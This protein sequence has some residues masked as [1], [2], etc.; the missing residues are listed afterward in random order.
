MYCINFQ[1]A[2]RPE[3]LFQRLMAFFEDNLLAVNGGLTHHGEQVTADED[4]SPSLE[5]TIVVLWLQLIHPGLPLLVKQKYGSELHNKILASLKPEISQALSS[6][7]DE[8]RSIEDTK[9]MRISNVNPRRT[10]NGGQGQPRRR[11]FVSCI[12]CKTA[13][14]PHNTHDLMECRYLPDRDRRPWARS[15]LTN[16]DPDEFATGDC[17]PY[18]ECCDHVLPPEHSDAFTAP[19]ALSVS[20]IQSPVLNTFYHEHPVQL[21]LDT[22]ATSNMVRASAAKLYGLPVTP[23]SQMARQADG[24]TPMDVVGEVHCTLTRGQRAFELD[25]PVVR[26]LDVDILAGN[27]FLARNDI[28]I[29]PAR[30]QIVI[31][32][33]DMIHYGTASKHTTQSAVRRTQSFLLRN[34]QRT[35][36]LPGEYVQLDTPRDSD[37][38]TLWALEPRLDCPSNILLKAEGAWPPPQQVLSVDHAVHIT[39]T[40]DSP[41]LLKTGEQLCHVRHVIP[42]YNVDTTSAPTSTATTAP[43]CCQPFSTNVILDPDGCLDEDICDKFSALNLEF[44]DV[45]NPSIS[46]YN[47]ASGPIEAVVNI[48]PT[49][50]P[51]RKG[52]LPQYNRSTLEELQAKFDEL[53]VA[54]VFARPEQVNVHVEYLNTS[55]LVKKPNGGSRLVTSF[56]EVAQYSKPQPS[57]MPNVDGVLREIGKWEYIVFSDLLKSFYQIPLAHSSMKYCGVATP[58]KGIRVYTRSAMGMPGSETCLGQKHAS[59]S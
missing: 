49:L 9:A 19:T 30:R 29:H 32:G 22:G 57:L 34:P 38:D 42:V 37:P 50:P 39:N 41:I 10:S 24:V 16:D 46:K 17:G 56:G 28:S 36:I 52:R 18:N 31:G 21:T 3:D 58:F 51:Q 15:R 4:L 54:G 53:K 59:R 25:A 20:I 8:L 33:S 13:G 7:L 45:F 47:G 44:D 55:F 6:L 14:R 5:N 11:P 27:P 43:T 23:A 48:G 1:T 12:V 26:Q 2:E 35:V 40:T